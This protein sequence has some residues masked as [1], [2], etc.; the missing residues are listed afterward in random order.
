MKTHGKSSFVQ[1]NW[2]L[3]N[4]NDLI[5]VFALPKTCVLLLNEIEFPKSK[6]IN[7]FDTNIKYSKKSVH[8][9]HQI[10]CWSRYY[11]NR[12]YGFKWI[13]VYEGEKDDVDEE[14]K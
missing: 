7:I 11:Q 13:I 5:S 3:C 10:F 6:I 2:V 4:R 14:G 9:S 8:K 12:L 1:K